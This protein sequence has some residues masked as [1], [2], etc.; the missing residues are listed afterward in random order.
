MH[1]KLLTD[2]CCKSSRKSIVDAA[3]RWHNAPTT[4]KKIPRRL[5]PYVTYKV[6]SCDNLTNYI[7]NDAYWIIL[8]N[9]RL[10]SP[11]TTPNKRTQRKQLNVV[12]GLS[13][14]SQSKTKMIEANER[15]HISELD[16]NI[17]MQNRNFY[18]GFLASHVTN[19]G[20][21]VFHSLTLQSSWRHLF[22]VRYLGVICR[23]VLRVTPLKRNRFV[24]LRSRNILMQKNH[25]KVNQFVC[26]SL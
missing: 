4:G 23:N 11:K 20:Y 5:P 18:V 17:G 19:I 25:T 12:H 26:C 16:E 6:E 13:K 9:A 15:E 21:Y 7:F 1:H 24:S 8:P 22:K 2:D 10:H 14:M 3:F